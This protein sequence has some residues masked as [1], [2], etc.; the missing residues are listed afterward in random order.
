MMGGVVEINSDVEFEESI[1]TVG[2]A[3]FGKIVVGS[4]A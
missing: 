1:G 2:A 4:E 3:A